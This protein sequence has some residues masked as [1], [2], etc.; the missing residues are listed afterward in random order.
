MPLFTVHECKAASPPGFYAEWEVITAD[1]DGAECADDFTATPHMA[2]TGHN[3]EVLTDVTVAQCT[4]ACC[5]RSWCRSFDYIQSI[6][7]Y[8]METLHNIGLGTQCNF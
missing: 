4:A 5:A 6:I 3:N 1:A 8:H 2:M 7:N